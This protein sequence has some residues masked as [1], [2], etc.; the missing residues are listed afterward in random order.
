M[1]K[2]SKRPIEKRISIW[3]EEKLSQQRAKENLLLA[4]KQEEQRLKN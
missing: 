3:E 2:N 4:K 1:G